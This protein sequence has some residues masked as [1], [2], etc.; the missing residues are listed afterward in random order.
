[1][2]GIITCLLKKN[3]DFAYQNNKGNN[4]IKHRPIEVTEV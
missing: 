1:M 4:Y 2:I 3:E